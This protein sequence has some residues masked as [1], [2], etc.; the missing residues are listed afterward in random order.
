MLV[1]C[2]LWLF[3]GEYADIIKTF[4]HFQGSDNTKLSDSVARGMLTNAGISVYSSGG[5]SDR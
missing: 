1:Y 4:L 5:C 3:N 2:S